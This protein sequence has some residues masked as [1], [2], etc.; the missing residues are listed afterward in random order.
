MS[1]TSPPQMPFGALLIEQVRSVGMSLRK[2]A[3][4]LG[5]LLLALSV[6]GLYE[7]WS[8]A[9]GLNGE[10]EL[11]LTTLP[12]AFIFPF[13]VWKGEKIFDDAF[14]WT[15]PVSRHRIALAKVAAGAV[16]C[17]AGILAVLL[18][19]LLIT[20]VTGGTFGISETRLIGHGNQDL[21]E[22]AQVAWQTPL[23]MWLVPFAS[24]LILYLL[25]SAAVLGL[26][27]PVRLFAG[28]AFGWAMLAGL[29]SAAP[30]GVLKDGLS[31]AQNALLYGPFGLDP[32]L[33]AG[34]FG[35]SAQIISPTGQPIA[36]WRD[37]PSVEQWGA[38]MLLWMTLTAVALSLG[39]WRHWEPRF[40][41]S[42]QASAS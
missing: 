17:L 5:L 42:Q 3:I 35:L 11:L 12:V 27:H 16:W 25:G 40:R 29:L 7:A 18:W 38:A 6:V 37:L 39:L 30:S 8:H 13:A 34:A 9:A 2:E 33:T 20:L 1:T 31:A 28:A 26:R 19:I 21:P 4:L 22:F 15:F 10:P 24:G 14:L 32:A 36:I 23:W 41:W